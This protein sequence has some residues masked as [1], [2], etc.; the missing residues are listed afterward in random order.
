MSFGANAVGI[1]DC[2]NMLGFKFTDDVK[3]LTALVLADVSE[4]ILEFTDVKLASA[5]FLLVVT[6]AVNVVT[7]DAEAK[8]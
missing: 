7:S 4:A 8:P 2:L 3:V 6:V 5:E 1:D